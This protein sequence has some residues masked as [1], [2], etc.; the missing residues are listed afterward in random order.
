MLAYSDVLP[1]LLLVYSV[2]TNLC[3]DNCATFR[4]S[5]AE[6]KAALL[7]ESIQDDL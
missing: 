6:F 7:E 5:P 4:G 3:M 2:E 1:L